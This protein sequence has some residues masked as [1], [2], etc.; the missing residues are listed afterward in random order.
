M[1]VT[2]HLF[3]IPRLLEIKRHLERIKVYVTEACLNYGS[4]NLLGKCPRVY[5][6]L[7]ARIVV[8][9]TSAS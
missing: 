7:I 6:G 4:G 1:C 3:I 9:G 5:P 2:N 8:D